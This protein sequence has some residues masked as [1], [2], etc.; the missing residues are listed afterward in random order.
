MAAVIEKEGKA[1]VVRPDTALQ[2]PVVTARGKGFPV[3]DDSPRGLDNDPDGAELGVTVYLYGDFDELPDEIAGHRVV[4]S[5][6]PARWPHF[7]DPE[8]QKEWDELDK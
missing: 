1:V 7:T 3:P 8:C 2:R 5:L 6:D 4:R